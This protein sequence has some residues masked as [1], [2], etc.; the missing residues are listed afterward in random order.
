[1]SG[2]M[3]LR[4]VG[5]PVVAYVV[6]ATPFG[7]ILGRIKGVDIRKHGSGNVGATNV[8]RVL[9]K[10]WGYLCFILDVAKGLLP[11]LASGVLARRDGTLDAADQVA[12]LLAGVGAI[13]GHVFSFWLRFKGGKGVATSLGVVLGFWPYFTLPGLTALVVWI[14]VT[15]AWRYVSLG[16]IV[17]AMSFPLFF[18]AYTLFAGLALGSLMPMLVFAS[19]MASL[20]ILRHRA[21]IGRLLRGEENSIDGP[22]T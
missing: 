8:G 15:L 12:W 1:M 4:F 2:D 21:N 18:V 5:M 20:V 6:A 13:F 3:W 7:V 19:A 14:A 17:A 11:V 10:T 22:R 16:S 9:G